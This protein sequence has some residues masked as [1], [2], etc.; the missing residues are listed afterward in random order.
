[1]EILSVL[2]LE[3]KHKL[4]HHNSLWFSCIFI[5]I[6]ETYSDSISQTLLNTEKIIFSSSSEFFSEVELD[7]E[8]YIIFAYSS[9]IVNFSI[10][11]G[12]ER[13]QP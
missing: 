5:Q 12:I 3:F 6:A 13:K 9:E 7:K 4:L 8:I 2:K 11:L 1:M 10:G